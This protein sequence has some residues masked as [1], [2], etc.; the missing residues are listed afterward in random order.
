[1]VGENA[2]SNDVLSNE[3]MDVAAESSDKQ[4]GTVPVGSVLADWDEDPKKV[5][6]AVRKSGV[7]GA[8]R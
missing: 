5:A 1:M 8:Q 4:Q 3:A 2:K 6:E 7:R